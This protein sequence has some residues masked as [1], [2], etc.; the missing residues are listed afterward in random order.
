MDEFDSSLEYE[1]NI[2]KKLNIKN[3]LIPII[4]NKFKFG[5]YINYSIYLNEKNES[6][7]DF[8]L[9]SIT[10]NLDIFMDSYFNLQK[11]TKPEIKHKEAMSKFIEKHSLSFFD[12]DSIEMISLR[13]DINKIRQIIE[14]IHSEIFKIFQSDIFKKN[15]FCHG[16]LNQFN[17]LYCFDY[18]KF[19]NLCDS[20]MG[21]SYFDLANLVIYC[22]FN[23]NTEKKIFDIFLK[24]KKINS[25]AEEWME[26]RQCFDLVL[27][28]I[29]LQILFNFL[30][31]TYLFESKRPLKFLD[32]IDIFS[33]NQNN[34]LKIPI[35]HQNFE[36]LY[37]L[38]LQPLIGVEN[39]NN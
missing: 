26:Y 18:F 19:I 10:S 23:K 36:F 15:E 16:N 1:F 9:N 31:E 22:G 20:F 25:V 27:R 8:G 21:N 11:P 37:N 39:K 24:N 38:F 2:I 3:T 13:Y 12:K 17:I 29:F 30:K 28:K 4:F 6:V 5:D 32:V 35:I 34:F 7:K 33:K 14:I